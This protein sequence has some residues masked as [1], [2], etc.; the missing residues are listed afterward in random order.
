MLSYEAQERGVEGTHHPSRLPSS[1]RR[2]R[3]RQR[4]EDAPPR[5]VMVKR[6]EAEESGVSDVAILGAAAAVS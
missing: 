3:R 6:E 1:L 4:T 2:G 5:P